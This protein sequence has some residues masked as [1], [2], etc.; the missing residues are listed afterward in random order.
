MESEI[1][2]CPPA[3]DSE[4]LLRY[5]WLMLGDRAAARKATAEL[6]ARPGGAA[7]AGGGRQARVWLLARARASCL[8]RPESAAAEVRRHCEPLLTPGAGTGWADSPP[9][10]AANAVL[11]LPGPEREVLAL[12][13]WHGLTT[14]EAALV[15]GLAPA[16]VA[17]LFAAAR[18]RLSEAV[19]GEVLARAS[20]GDCPERAGLLRGRPAVVT[21]RLRGLLLAHA[22]ACP[23]CGRH[24]PAEVSERKVCS[25]LP[26]GK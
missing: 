12:L 1:C 15:T 7:T 17:A 26:F 2:A 13:A 21:P 10:M 24:L 3:G 4:Y 11:S 8:R 22:G 9:A 20:A 25:L 18:A 19:A 6:L 23:V 16:R 14:A 5:C